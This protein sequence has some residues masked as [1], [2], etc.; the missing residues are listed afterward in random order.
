[1][2]SYKSH[3]AGPSYRSSRLTVLQV[4]KVNC[5]KDHKGVLLKVNDV[6]HWRTIIKVMKVECLRS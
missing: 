2:N 3:D 1:M 5:Q 4:I 6:D